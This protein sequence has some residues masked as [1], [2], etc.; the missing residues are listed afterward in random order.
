MPLHVDKSWQEIIEYAYAGLRPEYREFLEKD[1]GYFPTCKNFLNAFKTLPLHKTKYILLG[2]DPYPREQSASG[3]AFIDGAVKTLF[4]D[5]GFSKEV[6][7][8]TSL[9]NFLKMLLVADGYLKAD[10]VSQ[11]AI[12][13]LDKSHLVNSID[14]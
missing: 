1:E 13:K 2:Q 9:R 10:D 12:S 6:N 7:K 4:S 8:A 3:Y 14:E 11:E 5:K